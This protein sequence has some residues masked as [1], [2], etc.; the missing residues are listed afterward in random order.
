MAG[1]CV[2]GGSATGGA[3][4]GGSFAGGAATG[5]ATTQASPL[6]IG[7]GPLGGR[8]KIVGGFAPTLGGGGG[9]MS[10]IAALARITGGRFATFGK[11][12]GGG[13]TVEPAM[14]AGEGIRS[15]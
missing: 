5:G 9:A 10:P 14:T 1:G 8:S 11:T 12:I 4:A 15:V 6:G 3:M 7:G 13:G 2:A